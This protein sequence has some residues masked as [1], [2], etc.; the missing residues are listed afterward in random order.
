MPAGKHFRTMLS[1]DL[2]EHPELLNVL[3]EA[4]FGLIF[5]GIEPL[6]F[7]ALGSRKNGSAPTRLTGY[8][9]L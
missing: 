5:C 1:V 7:E 3:P 8:F 6:S 4:G 9:P 2:V